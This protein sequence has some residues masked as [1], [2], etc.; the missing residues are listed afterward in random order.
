[1]ELLYFMM[2]VFQGNWLVYITPGLLEFVIL[3]MS[4]GAGLL[5]EDLILKRQAK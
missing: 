1:M 3:A 5:L 4:V 2:P